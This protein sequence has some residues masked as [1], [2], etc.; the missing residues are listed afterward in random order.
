MRR[1]SRERSGG[2]DLARNDHSAQLRRVLAV[3]IALLSLFRDRLPRRFRSRGKLASS[4]RF[5]PPLHALHSGDIRDYVAW[6]ALGAA[7][8]GGAFLFALR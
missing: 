8:I 2:P 6:L 7:L 5:C 1:D 3:A 4:R